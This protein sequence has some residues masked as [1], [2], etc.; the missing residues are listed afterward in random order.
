V[1]EGIEVKHPTTNRSPLVET[2]DDC[3]AALN[4]FLGP[5]QR[6]IVTIRRLTTLALSPTDADML[7]RALRRFASSMRDTPAATGG[8]TELL[9]AIAIV[10][11]RN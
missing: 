6:S 11:Q 8:V 1:V 9:R 5:F 10:T 7:T 3:I 2:V 4:S